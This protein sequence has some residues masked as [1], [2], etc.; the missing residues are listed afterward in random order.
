MLS[1]DSS[2]SRTLDKEVLHEQGPLG[3]NASYLRL[4]KYLCHLEAI[5]MCRA[6]HYDE[7]LCCGS[8]FSVQQWGFLLF[9]FYME[10]N[11]VLKLS[12]FITN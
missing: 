11:K 7:V 5:S 3:V 2:R 4:L 6:M 1:A 10:Q 12:E 9:F 8:H